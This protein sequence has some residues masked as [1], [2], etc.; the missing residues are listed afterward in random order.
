MRS[1]GALAYPHF[2]PQPRINDLRDHDPR[3]AGPPGRPEARSGRRARGPADPRR[4]H[5]R[6]YFSRPSRPCRLPRL[7]RLASGSANH[8][9]P[10]RQAVNTVMSTEG[11]P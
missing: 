4:K 5:S 10:N 7:T 3:A 9:P 8:S 2:P 11:S 1:A 6:G